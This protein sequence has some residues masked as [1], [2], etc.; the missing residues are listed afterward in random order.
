[1]KSPEVKLGSEACPLS[2]HGGHSSTVRPLKEAPTPVGAGRFGQHPQWELPHRRVAPVSIVSSLGSLSAFHSRGGK[3]FRGS[4]VPPHQSRD[5]LLSRFRLRSSQSFVASDIFA[6]HSLSV[7]L[8]SKRARAWCRSCF[9]SIYEATAR[10]QPRT[11]PYPPR[12]VGPS[13]VESQLNFADRIFI[14]LTHCSHFDHH[15]PPEA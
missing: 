10:R 7:N 3:R 8:Y 14:Y 5:L 12:H 15:L 6:G 1:M 4:R 2:A 9:P 11:R 13:L